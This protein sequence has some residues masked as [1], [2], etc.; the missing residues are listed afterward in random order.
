M[1]ASE[2]SSHRIDILNEI[3]KGYGSHVFL[4]SGKSADWV[5]MLRVSLVLSERTI[6][7]LRPS[8]ASKRMNI[9]MSAQ[10]G[11]FFLECD[12]AMAEGLGLN[13]GAARPVTTGCVSPVDSVWNLI[14]KKCSPLL[15]AGM[16]IV[17]PTPVLISLESNTSEVGGNNYLVHD[18]DST[19]LDGVW[20]IQRDSTRTGMS[21]HWSGGIVGADAIAAELLIPIVRGVPLEDLVKILIDE[22]DQLRALRRAIRQACDSIRHDGVAPSEYLADVVGPEIDGIT[23]RFKAIASYRT[24][25]IAGAAV[26]TVGVGLAASAGGLSAATA[27]FLGP[28]GLGLVA[29]E[30]A[31]FENAK[32]SLRE[33]P[34]FPLWKI[35]QKSKWK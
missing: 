18:V 28:A 35:S 19:R 13:T 14:D 29:R 3:D 7:N 32:N 12:K 31:E 22:S 10:W 21:M 20:N 2:L 30:Y 4:S 34:W 27:A 6:V 25:R 26:G 23:R 8:Q 15:E 9:I 17:T 1:L 33:S 24:L 5:S 11:G 16:L